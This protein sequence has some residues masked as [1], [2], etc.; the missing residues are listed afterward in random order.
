LQQDQVTIP[1]SF[2]KRT[3]LGVGDLL[4]AKAERGKIML[5]PKGLIDRDLARVE[6][7]ALVQLGASR[8]EVWTL[9]G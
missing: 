1:T 6:V 7:G 9:T 3:G 2:W 8:I 5:A 4:E